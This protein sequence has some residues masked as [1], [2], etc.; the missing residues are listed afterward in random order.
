MS[1]NALPVFE[2]AAEL[3]T[4]LG[5]NEWHGSRTTKLVHLGTRWAAAANW[6]ERRGGPDR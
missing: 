1:F 6:V 4:S 3:R 2:S 5:R